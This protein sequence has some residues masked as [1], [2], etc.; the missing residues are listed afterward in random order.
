MARALE[1]A[2]IILRFSFNENGTLKWRVTRL[3]YIDILEIVC[4]HFEHTGSCRNRNSERISRGS[5]K[6]GTIYAGFT[7]WPT[8]PTRM[9][10]M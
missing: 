10:I 6:M 1:S 4:N 5:E 7:T 9:L 2:N 3:L 8:F